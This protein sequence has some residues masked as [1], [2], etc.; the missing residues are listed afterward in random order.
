MSYNTVLF[1]TV[2]NR[3]QYL[4]ASIE[5]ALNQSV[6]IK[7]TFVHIIM[8]NGSEDGA[9]EIAKEY[10]KKHPHIELIDF[11]ENIHQLPAYNYG[12]KYVKEKYPEIKYYADLDSDDILGK[13]AIEENIRVMEANK[14]VMGTYS[15]FNV[16]DTKGRVIIKKHP[17]SLFVGKNDCSPEC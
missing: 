15:D 4:S 17:K 14:D 1:T 6:G 2:R 16:I 13:Y 3:K 12:M 9:F 5:S 10:A 11:G 7:N 8:N